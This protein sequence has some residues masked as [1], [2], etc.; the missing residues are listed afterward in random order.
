MSIPKRYYLSSSGYVVDRVDQHRLFKDL[1]RIRQGEDWQARGE[2]L[3]DRLNAEAEASYQ[4][5]LQQS[6]DWLEVNEGGEQ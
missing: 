6:G 5:I 4:K 2:A 1:P 3:V